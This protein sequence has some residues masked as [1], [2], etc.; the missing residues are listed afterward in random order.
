MILLIK[1]KLEGPIFI[2]LIPMLSLGPLSLEFL[3]IQF[4]AGNSQDCQDMITV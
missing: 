1:A 2:G 3:P 4:I